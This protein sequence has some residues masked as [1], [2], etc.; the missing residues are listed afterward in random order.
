M[1]FSLNDCLKV[2]VNFSIALYLVVSWFLGDLG[3]SSSRLLHDPT[4]H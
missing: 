1:R 2:S 3:R 4:L